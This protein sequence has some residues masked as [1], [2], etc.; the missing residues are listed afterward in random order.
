MERA[1]K[2]L[3]KGKLRDKSTEG[4][5]FSLKGRGRGIT[6]SRRK[7]C[8]CTPTQTPA[9][10]FLKAEKEE[11]GTNLREGENMARLSAKRGLRCCFSF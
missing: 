2:K 11:K 4:N 10:L 3:V 1:K 6:Q 8:I 5:T 9:F 7:I